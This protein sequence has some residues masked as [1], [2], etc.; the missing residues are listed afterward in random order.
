MCEAYNGRKRALTVRATMAAIHQTDGEARQEV[1]G[2]ECRHDVVPRRR[3]S[4]ASGR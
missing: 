1:R 2:M 3:R 4:K